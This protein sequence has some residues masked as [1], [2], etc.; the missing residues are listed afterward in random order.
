VETVE[1]Q[2]WLEQL[3]LAAVL[4]VVKELQLAETAAQAS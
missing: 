1:Q 2:E 3:I 4:G